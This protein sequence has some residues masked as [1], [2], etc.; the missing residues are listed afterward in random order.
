MAGKQGAFSGSPSGSQ[1]GKIPAPTPPPPPSWSWPE[2]LL[3]SRAFK[4]SAAAKKNL[5]RTY[6]ARDRDWSNLGQRCT[7]EEISKVLEFGTQIYLAMVL[8]STP[9]LGQ[10]LHAE[11]SWK[12]LLLQAGSFS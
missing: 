9:L 7:L 11:P 10:A 1:E 8:K 12:R 3:G 5:E 2:R 4:C 6:L